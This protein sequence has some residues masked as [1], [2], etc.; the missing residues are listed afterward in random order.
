MIS[1]SNYKNYPKEVPSHIKIP[2]ITLSDMLKIVVENFSSREAFICQGQKLSFKQ[3]D[4]YSDIFAG[5]LQH[6]WRVKKGQHIAIMLPNLLQFPII[7][8]ALIK[9]GS[10]F[11]NI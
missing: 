10:V 2:E 6:K 9:L 1:K 8:F 7:I 3:V 5:Y 11:I 4:E